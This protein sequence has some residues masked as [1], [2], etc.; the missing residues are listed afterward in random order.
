MKKNVIRLNET[1]LRQIVAESV[2]RILKES[3]EMPGGDLGDDEEDTARYDDNGYLKDAQYG[4]PLYDDINKRLHAAI[5][6]GE[7]WAIVDRAGSETHGRNIVIAS[8]DP[9]TLQAVTSVM[10]EMGYRY[11][12]S[13]DITNRYTADNINMSFHKNGMPVHGVKMKNIPGS[14]ES[15]VTFMFAKRSK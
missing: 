15:V 3:E 6:G 11:L 2:K 5:G 10:A 8:N 4:S 13:T 12:Q 9:G 7:S 14:K 1:Q